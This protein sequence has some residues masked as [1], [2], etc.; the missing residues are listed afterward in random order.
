[1]S[2][3]ASIP[4]AGELRDLEDLAVRVSREA[5]ELITRQRP[6]DLGVAQT[7]SSRTDVVTVMDQ[8]AQDLLLARLSAA[9]PSDAIQ[10][11]EKGSVAGSS[12]LTWVVD[13]ID[14]TT[15]YLYGMAAYAVSVAVVVGDPSAPGQW[16]PV[17]GAVVNAAT[18]ET[19]R[20]RLGG[21]AHLE[22]PGHL[23]RRLSVLGDDDLGVALVATG[24]AY[25]AQMRARQADLLRD[26]LPQVRDI[27]RV[28]SAAL[29]LCRLAGGEVDA[30]Y[31]SQLNAWD[32]AAGWLV[33]TEAGCVVGGPAPGSAPTGEL[34]WAA[35]PAL[36][37]RFGGVIRDLAARHTHPVS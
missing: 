4:G 36:A 16:R 23:G 27:R 14:G 3:D 8:R 22:V 1:M 11:E 7:K 31:E 33:A 32:L 30:Y 6:A 20:A 28:G 24:F 34:L 13:P 25:G 10:G 17:A 18:G 37:E 21:G 19:Y 9:R 12:G 35:A 29:D 26:L 5:A 15:N 2:A